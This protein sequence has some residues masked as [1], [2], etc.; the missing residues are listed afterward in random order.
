MCVCFCVNFNMRPNWSEGISLIGLF[1]EIVRRMDFLGRRSK[2]NLSGSVQVK[3]LTMGMVS[4][5]G[6]EYVILEMWIMPRCRLNPKPFCNHH[7]EVFGVRLIN[8]KVS[9]PPGIGIGQILSL[10]TFILNFSSCAG[11]LLNINSAIYLFCFMKWVIFWAI[12]LISTEGVVVENSGPLDWTCV[13][14]YLCT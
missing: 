6:N 3:R 2:W 9:S 13:A 8:L 11:S 1:F 4:G 12:V 10:F 7:D 5:D 14:A